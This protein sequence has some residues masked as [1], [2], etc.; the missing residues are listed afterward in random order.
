MFTEAD[1]RKET[2]ERTFQRGRQLYGYGNVQQI[3]VTDVWVDDRKYEKIRATVQ[4]SSWRCYN[5]NITVQE[6]E[7]RLGSYH[8]ECPASGEY[9]GLCKHEVAA[10]LRYIRV[11][12]DQRRRLSETPDKIVVELPHKPT[13]QELE[14]KQMVSKGLRL[15][16]AQGTPRK[17][18]DKRPKTDIGLYRIL[19]GNGF[20]QQL[21]YRQQAMKG[22]VHLEPYCHDRYSGRVTVEFKIG[23]TQQYVLKN[24]ME[25]E[26]LVRRN[27]NKKYGEKLEFYHHMSMFD[28]ESVPLVKFL[29][30]I[31][32]DFKTSGGISVHQYYSK[33]DVKREI[34]LV[35]SHLDRFME[36][37]AGREFSLDISGDVGRYRMEDGMPERPLELKKTEGGITVTARRLNMVKGSLYQYTCDRERKLIYRV[38]LEELAP[39]LPFME[40]MNNQAGKGVFIAESELP[41]LC[42]DLLPNLYQCYQV[43]TEA[44]DPSGYLPEE[45]DIAI[46]LDMPSGDEVSCRIMAVY[47]EQEYNVTGVSENTEA[48]SFY[49]QNKSAVTQKRDV[50]RELLADLEIGAVFKKYDAAKGLR[51]LSGD[52]DVIYEFLT[53]GVERL[54]E[55][56]EVFVSEE[57]KKLQVMRKLRFTVGVS[58][59]SGLLELD[60]DSPDMSLERLAEIL[61]KYD[62][63]KKYYR[64]RD[65]SFINMEDSEMSNVISIVDGLRLTQS[66]LK[67]GTVSVPKYRALYLDS[68]SR[69]EGVSY[70]HKDRQFRQLVRN[71]KSVEDCDYE[72]P[73]ELQQIMREY[74]KSGYRWLKTLHDNGFGGILADDMGLGKTLQVI[75]F[76]ASEYG[77]CGAA[78]D[79][80]AQTPSG[81]EGRIGRT[82]IVCPA[83]LVYNWQSE[84]ERFA[85]ALTVV[86]ITGDAAQRRALVE[87]SAGNA[88][89]IT[90]YDLLKRDI[91]NYEGMEFFCEVIDEAQFI[92]NQKTQAARAVKLIAAGTRFALT[93]TPMEN[94]LSELWSI[95]D[96]LMPGFLFAY[97]QFKEEIEAPIVERQDETA[98]LQLRRFITPF[99]LRRL[100]KDVLKDLPD[101]LE[102]IVYAKMEQEQQELYD[103]AVTKLR[104]MLAKQTDEEFKENKLQVLAELTRLRQLC[105]NPSLI[106]EN[107]GGAS[108][109]A[110]V[111]MELLHNAIEGGHKV[112]LF[113]QFTSLL[114]LLVA[115][116][117]REGITFF[118]LTGQTP[119]EERIR[120][121]DAFNGGDTQVFFISLRAGGTGLNLTSADIVIHF[122]PWWNVA[123]QNQA[124]DRT[125][126]IGQKN[127]VTVYKLIAKGTIEEKIVKLQ[128]AKQELAEQVLGGENMDRATLSKEELLELL[129]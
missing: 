29:L 110:E 58:L 8:C 48:S 9:S 60:I 98:L 114:E 111:C 126:R 11:K 128:E 3:Q 104:L 100:K 94:R 66:Q 64:L 118:K 1:I 72:V 109:K 57:M 52:S 34:P 127:V 36:A 73:Q 24:V 21:Q 116:A 103:A 63:R 20:E 17:E 102:E 45:A 55:L 97:K 46:Y 101:K 88:I 125:H 129:G 30:E 117:R 79:A 25:F 50:Q 19:V 92:K 47:G 5:V 85:P 106:Y 2:M 31:V 93:G 23:I 42:R 96:Y 41:M 62:R 51:L 76:L 124:T 16:G 12:E 15:F 75:A 4:G 78:Q 95:F 84:I 67:K 107:Y 32:S 27:E 122:D 90:S 61:S 33:N 65:G 54:H 113:S 26:E 123:A 80:A 68:L 14:K 121:V 38:P 108:A 71:M 81:S 44:F 99:V 74:Q 69:E 91:E 115:Q 87:E 6:K 59:K 89:L 120:M 39:V 53:E 43:K 35:G 7:R 13:L 82:L 37:M 105:C 56:G 18:Q 77:V 49:T 40:Y 22:K 86:T 70:M 28:E 83:S 112:L 119:K 10:L